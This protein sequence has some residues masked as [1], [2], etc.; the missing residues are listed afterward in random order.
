MTYVISDIHGRYFDLLD[1]LEKINFTEQDTLYVLGDLVD[2]GPDSLLVL[3]DLQERRNVNLL[4]GN[5][6]FRMLTVL[7]DYRISSLA[8]VEALRK[9]DSRIEE[10]LQD[11]GMSTLRD[12][13][14][15]GRQKDRNDIQ[16]WLENAFRLCDAV[17][18]GGKAFF[19][20]HTVPSKEKMQ[21]LPACKTEDF[22]YGEPEYDKRYFADCEI[23]TGHTPT[24][25]ID[26]A[27]RGKILHRNGHIA[28]DCGAY[29]TGVLGCL[30][31]DT[32]EEYYIDCRPYD[33]YY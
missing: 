25:M 23:I 26:P 7:R 18:V 3:A 27:S 33:K 8:D 17:Q 24:L 11:G 19:L 6:D 14:R 31:L 29:I 22:L 5:H 30:C 20:A 28:I 32:M 13:C 2:R 1:L 9:T 16:G 10:W 4:W 21:N 12:F 15:M